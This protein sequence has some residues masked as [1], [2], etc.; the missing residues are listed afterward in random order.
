MRLLVDILM[1]LLQAET[2][3]I[4]DCGKLFSSALASRSLMHRCDEL[5]LGPRNAKDL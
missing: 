1:L 4:S 5:T 3:S 2:A